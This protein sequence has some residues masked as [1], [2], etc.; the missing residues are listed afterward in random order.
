MLHQDEIYMVPSG[1]GKMEGHFPVRE[2][3]QDWKSQGILLKIL[4]KSENIILEIKKK[5]LERSG[6]FVSQ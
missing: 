5:I 6:K 2:F 1:T 3:C 4:K